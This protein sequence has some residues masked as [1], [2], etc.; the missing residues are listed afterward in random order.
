MARPDPGETDAA[1]TGAALTIPD[2]N[3]QPQQ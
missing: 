1:V 3:V 2:L